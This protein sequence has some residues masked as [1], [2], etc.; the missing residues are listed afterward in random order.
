M[1]DKVGFLPNGIRRPICQLYSRVKRSS[2]TAA[3]KKV[4]EVDHRQ[5]QLE[6]IE[7]KGL[8]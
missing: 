1:L 7:D 5:I 8:L 3:M 4:D 2:K 6:A